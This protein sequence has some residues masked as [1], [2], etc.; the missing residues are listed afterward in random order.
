MA[1]RAGRRR[2]IWAI[3]LLVLGVALAFGPVVYLFGR[4][5]PVKQFSENMLPTIPVGEVLAMERNPGEVR[6]GDVITYDP[7]DWGLDGPFIGRVVALGGDHV[8]YAVGDRT[9]TLNGKPLDEPYLGDGDPGAGGVGFAVSVPQGRMFVLGD[10][11]G[12]SADSRF[13]QESHAGTL[14]V[15]AVT[16][17][18]SG[19]HEEAPQM[20]ALGLVSTAGTCLLPVGLGLGIAS[21][22]ARRRRPAEVQGPVWGATRVDAP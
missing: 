21:L 20:L 5:T 2:G 9:L 19:L 4:F 13:H 16:G 7:A 12:N 3:A 1:R 14:P 6:H 18:D 10:N 17:L 15:S 8:A 11:R 22:V